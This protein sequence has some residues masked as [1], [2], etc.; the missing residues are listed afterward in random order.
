MFECV[1]FPSR[2]C[3]PAYPSSLTLSLRCVLA[4]FSDQTDGGAGVGVAAAGG[5][6]LD[7][8]TAPDEE[9]EDDPNVGVDDGR[10]QDAM[11]ASGEEGGTTQC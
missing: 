11:P 6:I 3:G 7:T 5:V 1:C 4:S 2:Q 8:D 9:E 10:F